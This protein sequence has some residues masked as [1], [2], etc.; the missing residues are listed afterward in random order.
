MLALACAALYIGLGRRRLGSAPALRGPLLWATLMLPAYVAL[1][2]VPLPL[3]FLRI[4][5]PARAAVQQ[6]LAAVLPIGAWAPLS[7]VPAATARSLVQVCACVL[8][9]L[10]VREVAWRLG[11]RVWLLALPPAAIAVMEGALGMAQHYVAPQG[12]PSGTFVNHNHFAGFLEMAL[13]LAALAPL[14]LLYHQAFRMR[15]SLSAAALASLLVGAAA[16]IFA[17]ILRSLSKMGFIASV[18]ALSLCWLGLWTCWPRSSRKRS[19]RSAPVIATT[20]ILFAGAFLMFS[21][22]DLVRRFGLAEVRGP[23]W[24]ESLPLAAAYPL[25]GCGFG[26]YES[27]FMQ[28]K[29]GRPMSRDDYAHNDYL[30]HFIELG[31]AGC[32]IAAWLGWAVL[33]AAWSA[34][35]SHRYVSGRALAVACVAS[36]GAIAIHSLTDFNLYI[37]ANALLLSWVCGIAVSVMFSSVEKVPGSAARGVTVIDLS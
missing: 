28:Y 6:A 3:A 29:T 18:G 27:A 2:L 32:A 19:V 22:G 25:F 24:A 16:V 7:L 37:P 14:G 13:P 35:R 4:V 10:A 20:L 9:F 33:R 36:L 21:S 23:L 11:H 30:Q 15:Q 8:L 1:Q 12:L 34:A 17:G 5:S 31:A 26:C